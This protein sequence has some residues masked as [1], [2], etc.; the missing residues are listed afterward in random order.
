QQLLSGLQVLIN[1]HSVEEMFKGTLEVISRV[2]P[3][4]NA[5]VLVQN[6]DGSLSVQMSTAGDFQFNNLVPGKSFSR[7]LAGRPVCVMDLDLLPEWTAIAEQI[8]QPYSS[9]LLAPLTTRERRGLLICVHQQRAYFHKRH[10]KVLEYFVPL[11]AQALQRSQEIEELEELVKRLDEMAHY[12]ALTGICN[13]TLFNIILEKTI[14]QHYRH[15]RCSALLM[16]DL[17]NFKRINDTLGHPAGDY[18]LKEVA[19]RIT[20]CVRSGDTVARLGGDE[21]AVLLQDLGDPKETE[22]IAEKILSRIG[23]P[24]NYQGQLIHPSSSIGIT[25]FPDDDSECEQLMK[26]A[27]MALYASKENGRGSFSFFSLSM[28]K[29][30]ESKIS[31]ENQLRRSLEGEGLKLCYQPIY[32]TSDLSCVGMEALVRMKKRG[33]GL[34]GPDRFIPIAEQTGLIF[35][36]GEWV[37]RTACADLEGWLAEAENSRVAINVSAIQLRDPDFAASVIDTMAD[38]R[39]PQQSVEIELSEDII[40]RESTEWLQKNIEV[41]YRSGFQ[42]AFDD[43][44]RGYSSLLHLRTFPGKRLKIDRFF[45]QRMLDSPKDQV[46]VRSVIDMAHDMGMSVVAEGVETPEQLKSLADF[47]CDEVQGFLLGRPKPKEKWQFLG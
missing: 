30:I 19:Q 26:N 17:D 12:D 4:E 10:L 37:L 6:D 39:V 41:L 47:G 25:I 15:R 18:L 2:V 11:A 23:M 3:F 46:I 31:L 22:V 28:R 21:F 36:L 43:F 9:A 45:V 5:A 20:S 27:D 24:L 8:S 38:L 13:R 44:G 34:I 42:I 16:L 7:V 33:S 1:A 32:R 29:K 40:I 14:S 35:P